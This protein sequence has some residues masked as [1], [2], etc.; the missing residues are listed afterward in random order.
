ME[1]AKPAGVATDLALRVSVDPAGCL[2]CAACASLAPELF[3]IGA[4]ASRSLRAP[5]TPEE[6]A[7]VRA[8]ALLCPAQAITLHG[9][10][11]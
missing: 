7:R 6:T 10:G 2:R 1:T 4:H 9:D 5:A 8:A 11:P 3:A